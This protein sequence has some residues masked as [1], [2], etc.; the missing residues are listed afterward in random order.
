MAPPFLFL[1]VSVV[2]GLECYNGA[3]RAGICFP[4]TTGLSRAPVYDILYNFV[5]W[6]LAILGFIGI[7]AF[8]ISGMQYL[9]SAG[10]E[11][12]A[13]T[14]KSSMKY[15]IIGMVVALSGLVIIFAIDAVLRG[16]SYF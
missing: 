4:I 12:M 2:N 11:E 5:W 13:K 7:I 14:A 16:F 3:E 6:L 8:V 9:L 1:N 10:S 15:S